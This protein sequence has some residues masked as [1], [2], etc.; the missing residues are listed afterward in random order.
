MK[1]RPFERSTLWRSAFSKKKSDPDE[2]DRQALAEA[3]HQLRERAGALVGEIHAVLPHL[4]V[5]D[6]TH[7]DTLW[8]V[9]SEICGPDYKLNPLQAFV[10]GASFLL[11]DAG[12]ALAAYPGGLAELKATA[13]YRDAIVAAWKKR[14]VDEPLDEQRRNPPDDLCDEA[15]F[16]VL[17]ARHASQAKVLATALWTQPEAGRP[18]ALVQ[19]DDLLESYGELIGNISAS[20]H[21]P[22][23]E[24]GRF[25]GDPT[26]ASAAWPRDWE[27]DGL[28]LA[29][30]LRCADACAIDETR[31]PS[32][33][34]A[35]RKPQGISKRHWT[36]Q[37]KLYPGKRRDDAV[38]FE[39]KSAFNDQQ[40]GD[41]WLCFDAISVA[42][43]ELRGSDAL[44]TD[45]KRLPFLTRRIIGANDPD[46]LVQTVKVEGWKPVN[47]Q[48]TISDPQ[49]LIERL[50]GKQLYGDQPIVPIRELFQNAADAVRARRFLDPFFRATAMNRYPG[51]ILIQ[52]EKI[53]G[54]K[55][56]WLS[57]ED[58]GIGMSERVITRSLL[59]FGT[60]FWSS[61]VAAE[62][63]PGLPSAQNFR[64]IG[65]YGIGFFSVFM[66]SENVQVISREFRGA[67]DF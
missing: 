52:I 64:P 11:H 48:P 44:L 33:L 3:Y 58:N 14:G 62:L 27:V 63:Y 17:R 45:R 39:S 13:Q 34:F 42:D 2:R 16:Q 38:V 59:D 31:A 28:A 20:H 7:A 35:L 53:P 41:W 19:N 23:T 61:E 5:H 25:F 55:D 6:L 67:K 50:G 15:I 57:V 1:V 8:D 32:F 21:W 26:P 37:N 66:Y 56:Y 65:R 43:K 18:M 24:L 40:S 47:T 9:G 49:S 22:I 46:I 36:F 29:C 54:T 12:M 51:S 4:T 10:L 60:S 30:I